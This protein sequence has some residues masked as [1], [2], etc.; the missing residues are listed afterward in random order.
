MN[1]M[2]HPG[3]AGS[4]SNT[5]SFP[6]LRRF[7]DIE[8][9]NLFAHDATD[10][11]ILAGAATALAALAAGTGSAGTTR[12]G[13]LAVVGDRYGA[14]TLGA[15][16][17]HGL[18]GIRVHQDA[19]SGELALAANAERL[20]LA[21][22]YAAMDLS[23][24]LVDGAT[25]VLWQLPRS[26]DELEETAALLRA[27]AAP[28]VQVVAGG[29][30]KHMALAMNDVLARHFEE[31]VPGRAWRKSRLLTVGGPRQGMPASDFPRREFNDALGLWL[32]AHG[33]TFGGTKLDLGTRFLLDFMPRMRPAATAIDLGCGNGS[34]AAALVS[35]RPGLKVWATDQSAAAVASAAATAEVNGLGERITAVR[36]D[37]LAGFPAGSADL[38][39]LNPPFHVGA[40]V[41][42]GIALKLF[43]AAARVLAPGGELWTVYNRHLDYRPQLEKRVGATEIMGRNSK[44]TVARSSRGLKG[45][46]VPAVACAPAVAGR[47]SVS[48]EVLGT[49]RQHV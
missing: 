34:I 48:A 33:A 14:L 44:F 3:P 27:H 7:P 21:G 29:R 30:V 5:F 38:V 43:D 39:V 18:S 45:R 2:Q 20:G 35:A 22:R 17:A 46:G 24:A 32:C 47:G 36:D 8:A 12:S 11:L 40:A 15:A 23:P 28:G 42:A 9:P 13:S 6:E 4:E 41:H 1:G 16:A 37:A 31:V 10:E 49:G 19:L 25:L 26:L